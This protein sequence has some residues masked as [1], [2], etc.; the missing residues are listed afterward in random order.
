MSFSKFY[1]SSKDKANNEVR[2]ER[3]ECDHLLYSVN[4]KL[5][6]TLQSGVTLLKGFVAKVRWTEV[7]TD[8]VGSKLSEKER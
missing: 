8:R 2:V 7:W 1:L 4:G 3:S 5:R 6:V